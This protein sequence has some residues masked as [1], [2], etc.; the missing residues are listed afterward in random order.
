[1]ASSFC[2]GDRHQ[3]TLAL[4]QTDTHVLVNLDGADRQI[5]KN[6]IVGWVQD[7]QRM[8][9]L[10][11]GR[12][13]LWGTARD[14]EGALWVELDC[15][16]SWVVS[17]A[18]WL[19]VQQLSLFAAPIIS[20]DHSDDSVN[21][22][23]AINGV[24]QKPIISDAFK[25]G[26][27]VTGINK[28]KGGVL[29]GI[30]QR[31]EG[32]TLVL[33]S[34]YMLAGQAVNLSDKPSAKESKPA[35]HD[36]KEGDLVSGV[37]LKSKSQVL[38][39]VQQIGNKYLSLDIGDSIHISGA[40]CITAVP[41]PQLEDYEE[42]ELAI[43][44]QYDLLEP[45]KIGDH[46]R[47]VLAGAPLEHLT[48]ALGTVEGAETCG[49]IP[50]LVDGFGSKFL[51]REQLDLLEETK[52]PKTDLHTSMRMAE[53]LEISLSA[54]RIDETFHPGQRVTHRSRWRG[55]SERSPALAAT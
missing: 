8:Q 26:D 9:C 29:Q 25:V 33:D 42:D 15:G 46:I 22:R 2:W 53:P 48:G 51:R 17:N 39:I 45:L 27:R 1:M 21:K 30:V 31:V 44:Q 47:I 54:Q 19:K 3:P 55:K 41:M 12:G 18:R 24:G 50:V 23:S 13:W 32:D 11:S 5:P 7:G 6:K 35:A 20:P 28:V 16:R 38:G 49:L 4:D 14:R 36:F 52:T 10:V 40:T 37:S 43:A 34:G